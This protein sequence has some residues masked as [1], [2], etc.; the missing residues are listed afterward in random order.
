MGAREDHTTISGNARSD[1]ASMALIGLGAAC[2]GGHGA[3][4]G[5]AGA[6]DHGGVP[7]GHGHNGGGAR[8]L[9]FRGLRLRYNKAYPCEFPWPPSLCVCT[10]N[11]C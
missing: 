8:A 7:F 11:P 9:A 2:G 10:D 4:P 6:S 3:A 1:G 5:V